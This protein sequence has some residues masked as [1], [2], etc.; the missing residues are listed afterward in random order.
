MR[1]FQACARARQPSCCSWAGS[2]QQMTPQPRLCHLQELTERQGQ[3]AGCLAE[4]LRPHTASLGSESPAHITGGPSGHSGA[5]TA[6]A[7]P[8]PL[9][10]ASGL[11]HPDCVLRS[12]AP[13]GKAAVASLD[14]SCTLCQPGRQQERAHGAKAR[15]NLPARVCVQRGGT[16]AVQ[17]T[18][19]LVSWTDSRRAP[20]PMPGA[21]QTRT[22]P[23][24]QRP[25]QHKPRQPRGRP[26][27]AISRART[28]KLWSRH[29]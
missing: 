14:V 13:R 18:C 27:S 2:Q 28:C 15:L 25:S 21:S 5:K 9:P 20:P 23:C 29:T 24:T 6:L 4:P 8:T 22:K 1:E 16:G 12:G 17:G 7:A 11:R 19:L 3:A 26:P 10:G